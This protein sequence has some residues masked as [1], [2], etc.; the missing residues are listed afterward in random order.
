MMQIDPLLF[1]VMT[2]LLL[3]TAGVSIGLAA[4][5]FTRRQRDKKAAVVLVQRIKEDRA[6]RK[7]E[8]KD[9]LIKR[10]GFSEDQVGEL[11]TTIDREE[12]RFYQVLINTYLQRDVSVFENLYIEYES[13]VD[14][15][16]VLEPP[17]QAAG[18]GE[19]TGE[20]DE[21]P[22]LMRLQTENKRLSE[23]VR[24]TMETM[25]RMLN[26]YS[27]MFAGGGSEELDKDKI[28]SMFQEQA[29]SLEEKI[30]AER[31]ALGLS[32][33]ES[34]QESPEESS[35]ESFG[36]EPQE[37]SA[38]L[39]EEAGEEE[40]GPEESADEPV[41]FGEAEG[42]GADEEESIE[43]SE[44]AEDETTADESGPEEIEKTDWDPESDEEKQ[45]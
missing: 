2:E 31:A 4:I 42:A 35:E 39:P 10:F 8:T 40:S 22:E 20:Y 9:I 19:T 30:N 17:L 27:A 7:Q 11:A 29:A 24:I 18:T 43:V 1:L 41:M 15:Y 44:L 6:R 36:G 45:E 33:A 25:G 32:E 16:R 12:K 34:A 26:E 28:K 13:A 38:V 21:S 3:V 37:E 14:P 23:E 5:W